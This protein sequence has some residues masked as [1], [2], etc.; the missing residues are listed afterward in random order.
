VCVCVCVC[1]ERE[2]EREKGQFMRECSL[3]SPP[4]KGVTSN[5]QT[6]P[7]VQEKATVKVRVCKSWGGGEIWSGVP[8]GPENKIDSAGEAQ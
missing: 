1:V 6:S 3:E 2:R 7:L 5:N 4:V 8:T